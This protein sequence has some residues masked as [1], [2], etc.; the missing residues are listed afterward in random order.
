MAPLQLKKA[1]CNVR[2]SA[3][4]LSPTI[5]LTISFISSF[6][7]SVNGLKF[8]N[9]ETGDP[10]PVR[11][12]R[13][14]K[15]C[16]YIHPN[17]PEWDNRGKILSSPPRNLGRRKSFGSRIGRSRSRSRN[18]SRSR[19]RNRSRSRSRGR[20][21]KST[22]RSRGRGDNARHE[23]PSRRR[24]RLSSPPRVPRRPFY[25]RIQRSPLTR[26]RSR[27]RSRP[28]GHSPPRHTKGRRPRTPTPISSSRG[29]TPPTHGKFYSSPSRIKAEPSTDTVPGPS[30]R[31]IP[32]VPGDRATVTASD[33]TPVVPSQVSV[34]LHRPTPLNLSLRK[35]STATS[36]ILHQFSPL[37]DPLSPI[38]AP[39]TPVIP[40]FST[41]VHPARSGVATMSALQKS[42][43]QIIK[44][45]VANENAN[46]AVVPA[47]GNSTGSLPAT[48][49][50]TE[51]AEIWTTRVKLVDSSGSV[52][53][54]F[55]LKLPECVV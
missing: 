32:P 23:S 49:S 21:E 55:L 25:E 30:S 26:P 20:R 45:Q 10:D 5:K 14:S 22:S 8:F 3:V 37:A 17:E 44:N 24:P 6:N 51:K 31:P 50:E 38:F 52:K 47:G 27:S 13:T 35:T 54:M 11:C 2:S 7:L 16:W 42:L 43:E 12:P 36:D 29:P 15:V 28:R 19:V 39:E 48:I 9:P 18:R 40:G 53:V 41:S 1:K 4:S 34:D 46:S 33:Q